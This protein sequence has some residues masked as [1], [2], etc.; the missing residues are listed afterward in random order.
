[1]FS[2]D[3]FVLATFANWIDRLLFL[4]IVQLTASGDF[5]EALALC[6]MLPPEDLNLRTAK[7]QSI[8]IRW[9]CGLCFY[10]HFYVK[11]VYVI[12]TSYK[13][14]ADV[15]YEHENCYIKEAFYKY[16]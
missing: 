1:M 12:S 3:Y 15:Y 2:T 16:I 5:E 7:E 6:K 14:F 11:M 13:C 10:Q 8:H 9:I 4:Q